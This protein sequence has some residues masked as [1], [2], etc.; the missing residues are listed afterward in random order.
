MPICKNNPKKNYT[1]LEPSPKGF[2]FCASG[3][4]EGIKMKGKDGNIWI[5]SNSRWKR[6]KTNK[7][8]YKIKLYKKLYKWWQHLAQGAIIV[9]YK[10]LTNKLIKS[11]MKTTKAQITD[12]NKIWNEFDNDANIKV[13]IWSAQSTDVINSFIDF[14]IKKNSESKLEEILK[15]KNI[16]SYL[17]NNYKKYFIKYNFFTNKDYTFKQVN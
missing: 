13:I 14:V 11:H 3:E 4:K 8:D 12:I 17:L 7:D 16:P 10:D 1:G 9:I 15:L 6:L 5:K 2:G